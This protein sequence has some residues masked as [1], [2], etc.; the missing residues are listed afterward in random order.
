[1]KKKSNEKIFY[2]SNTL[3]YP[4]YS[5]QVKHRI[6]WNQCRGHVP[7][8]NRFPIVS[9]GC[10]GS[11]VNHRSTLTE[12]KMCLPR[13]NDHH[14]FCTVPLGLR[15]FSL[16]CCTRTKPRNR[17]FYLVSPLSFRNQ[18]RKSISNRFRLLSHRLLDRSFHASFLL[19]VLFSA[20][21]I[22]KHA[23]RLEF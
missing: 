2:V 10:F 20:L 14:Q 12:G 16:V 3:F 17:N 1:M 8:F 5:I 4:S 19:L 15:T 21:F 7:I 13:R 23:P 6:G 18:S 9:A 11:T 22:R